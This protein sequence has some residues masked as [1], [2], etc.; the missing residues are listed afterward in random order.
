MAKLYPPVIE[1]TIPAFNGTVLTVPFSMN[2]SVSANQIS[3][4]AVKIKTVQSSTWITTL[5]DGKINE[6]YSAAI[7]DI[8]EKWTPTPGQYYKLQLAYI[9]ITGETGYFSTVGI[10]KYTNISLNN[11]KLLNGTEDMLKNPTKIYGFKHT[12]TGVYD[13]STDPMEKVYT[14]QFV[15]M[16][17]TEEIVYDSGVLLHNATK[18]TVNQSQDSY[19]FLDDL[20]DDNILYLQYKIITVNGLCLITPK[21]AVMALEELP[22]GLNINLIATNNYDN[23]YI[24]IMATGEGYISQDNWTGTDEWTKEKACKNEKYLVGQFHIY[25]CNIKNKRHWEP[26]FSFV[27]QTERPSDY[28][29]KDF[30]VE[31]GET[32]QYK[33]CQ[34][35]DYNILATAGYSNEVYVDFEDMFLFD[36]ERQLKIQYNPKVSNFKNDILE[37]KLDTI[38]SQYPFFFRNGH[39]HYKEFPISGLI[40]YWVDNEELFKPL[41]DIGIKDIDGLVRRDEI[42]NNKKTTDLVNYNIAAERQ[43]KLDVLEWLTNGKPKLFR[44]PAEG[45][46]IVRLM[47]TSLTPND[48]VGRMLHTF[49]STAYETDEFNYENLANYGFINGNKLVNNFNK[50]R[51]RTIHLWDLYN[52]NKGKSEIEVLLNPYGAHERITAQSVLIQDCEYLDKFIINGQ[53]TIIG[54]TGS[55]N[56]DN[57][58]PIT[59]IIFKPEDIAAIRNENKRDSSSY[60]NVATDPI[61]TYSYYDV[62]VDTSLFGNT[63]NLSIDSIPL[64]QF[65]GDSKTNIVEELEDTNTKIIKY[66]KIEI[67]KRPI[68]DLYCLLNIP[69]MRSL[70]SYMQTGFEHNWVNKL[71]TF[72][73]LGWGRGLGEMTVDSFE[74]GKNVFSG[75]KPYEIIKDMPFYL[76]RL[77]PITLLKKEQWDELVTQSKAVKTMLTNHQIQSDIIKRLTTLN[78]ATNY[79][80]LQNNCY[81]FLNYM[82]SEDSHGIFTNADITLMQNYTHI[83]DEYNTILNGFITPAHFDYV[84]VDKDKEKEP[85]NGVNYYIQTVNETSEDHNQE[86][87]YVYVFN[88]S[89]EGANFE[90]F[91]DIDLYKYTEQYAST[92]I[93]ADLYFNYDYDKFTFD[94]DYYLYYDANSG[95]CKIFENYSTKVYF[96]TGINNF[97]FNAENNDIDYIDLADMVQP[98]LYTDIDSLDNLYIGNGLIANLSYQY[99]V[100]NYSFEEEQ[101]LYDQ[102]KTYEDAIN[103]YISTIKNYN[104]IN[105][106]D[107]AD[108][109]A[110]AYGQ[111]VNMTWK[112][113]IRE[114]R[115]I[116]SDMLAQ[117]IKQ[118]EEENNANNI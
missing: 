86:Y 98:V 110:N 22:T 41:S 19:T 102:K 63:T 9:D 59:S 103:G 55:Y 13:Y 34:F 30:T 69:L 45:N 74:V 95:K 62:F 100:T 82:Q 6:D 17:D 117:R 48:T 116:Y 51:F 93:P 7:F 57:L 115:K 40:S 77:R 28:I 12:Y 111:S 15:L 18:D 21:I 54:A 97:D 112:E 53:E 87:V 101:E 26:I 52:K 11:L 44:S 92:P 25:R 68:E 38:G 37:S 27:L 42:P 67:D 107:P 78:S 91:E 60:L 47:N 114:Q 94:K 71:F 8:A 35:N 3:G 58:F 75:K 5:V 2:R 84:K 81:D 31:H 109:I 88:G 106:D 99:L 105:L 14:Y 90:D 70:S 61:I 113:Y 80:E 24:S 39:V 73:K 46:Y 96:N 33:I 108:S 20:E 83:I 49:N 4:F 79:I 50:L 23:G 65:I 16:N 43:F 89:D 85:L 29:L 118:W 72:D 64:Y 56:I 10:V 104:D 32:Y 1:G 36:G 76:F 66:Y